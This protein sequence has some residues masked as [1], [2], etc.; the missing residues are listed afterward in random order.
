MAPEAHQNYSSCVHGLSYIQ[1]LII[2]KLL[3]TN[4]TCFLWDVTW[5]TSQNH[6][7][8]DKHKWMTM[9]VNW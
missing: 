3:C 5:W 7:T 6:S 8:C 4:F 9:W 1:L 2:H